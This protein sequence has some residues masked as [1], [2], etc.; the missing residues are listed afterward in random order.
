MDTFIL[1]FIIR[2]NIEI[3]SLYVH[4]IQTNDNIGIQLLSKM[5]M[6]VVEMNV[7]VFFTK[8]KVYDTQSDVFVKYYFSSC[9]RYG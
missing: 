5:E 3:K 4:R 2:I 9:F 7:F 6:M 1:Y 8:C